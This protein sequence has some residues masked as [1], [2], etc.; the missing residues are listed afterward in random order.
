[1]KYIKTF[2]Q[3]INESIVN[4]T[5]NKNQSI[6]D[7]D[8]PEIDE[9]KAKVDPTEKELTKLFDKLVPSNGS[10]DTIEGEMVR[11]IMRIWYRYF[12]D[13]DYFFRGYGKET[14]G[15][16][17][18]FLKNETPISKDLSKLLS[19][20]KANAGAPNNRS[21]YSDDDEYLNG[22]KRVAKAVTDYVNSK[23]GKYTPNDKDSR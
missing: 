20:A 16:S 18:D 6:A 14:C 8:R 22:I 4:E 5:D 3:F 7:I 17:V 2:E 11:A 9:A 21:E 12:N 1:M 15:S 23:K 10:A 13:G 19:L